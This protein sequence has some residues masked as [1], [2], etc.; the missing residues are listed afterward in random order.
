MTSYWS[1]QQ[2]K[3]KHDDNQ[4]VSC[5]NHKSL[6]WW[7][8]SKNRRY[9]ETSWT[10]KV[11]DLVNCICIHLDREWRD[12][13]IFWTKIKLT[14]KAP[15]QCMEKRGVLKVV[16]MI[17][18]QFSPFLKLFYVSWGRYHNPYNLVKDKV[19]NK[20]HTNDQCPIIV[21]NSLIV[22]VFYWTFE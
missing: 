10:R 5:Y 21:I 9:C 17:V 20:L 8:R 4:L 6:Q 14:N 19:E 1:R 7:N 13:L 22:L 3:H 15:N 11:N 16:C 2:G 12:L 18:M